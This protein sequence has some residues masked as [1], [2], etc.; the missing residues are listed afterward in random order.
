MRKTYNYAIITAAAD[1]FIIILI[2]PTFVLSFIVQF[3]IYI[4]DASEMLC[5]RC[6]VCELGE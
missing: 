4:E 6:I 3:L 1:V 2:I 5:L